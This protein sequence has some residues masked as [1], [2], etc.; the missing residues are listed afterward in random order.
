MLSWYLSV[1]NSIMNHWW[2]CDCTCLS[3]GQVVSSE[4]W[5]LWE[6]ILANFQDNVVVDLSILQKYCLYIDHTLKL[7][8][9]N[10]V[11]ISQLIN[12]SIYLHIYSSPY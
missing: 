7:Y 9:F 10:N 3:K 4:N 2:P 11:T 1:S 6:N 12:I 8:L 5:V